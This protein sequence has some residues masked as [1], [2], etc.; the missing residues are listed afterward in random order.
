MC[1]G[2]KEN[3]LG[4]KMEPALWNVYFHRENCP[5]SSIVNA[6][7]VKL[8]LLTKLRG[9]EIERGILLE[10]GCSCSYSECQINYFLLGLALPLR[11]PTPI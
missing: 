10:R 11:A 6:F 9:G 1:A 4:R 8:D 7:G 2:E 5:N 3:V